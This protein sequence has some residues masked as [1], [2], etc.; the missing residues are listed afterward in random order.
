[1]FKFSSAYMKL[2][3]ELGGVVVPPHRRDSEFRLYL[4]SELAVPAL[5]V[6]QQH[7]ALGGVP[8]RAR[9]QLGLR[10]TQRRGYQQHGS[11]TS[12]ISLAL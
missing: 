12:H 11:D 6:V 10:P 2:Q 3:E 5:H 9:E 8:R 7:R 1:M 4:V